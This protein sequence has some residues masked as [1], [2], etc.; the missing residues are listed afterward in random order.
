MGTT[1]DARSRTSWSSHSFTIQ[2]FTRSGER[3]AEV[4]TELCLH[5]IQA[6]ADGQPGTERVERLPPESRYIRPVR[7]VASRHS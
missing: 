4:L 6:V 5:T 1:M 7:P 3:G 2:S